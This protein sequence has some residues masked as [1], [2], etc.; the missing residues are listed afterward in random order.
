LGGP[1][2]F[3]YCRRCG[4]EHLPCWKVFDCWWESFDVVD[5]L[6]SRLSPDQFHRLSQTRP[7]PKIDSL[8]E[9]V[10]QAKKAAG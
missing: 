2:T 8:L 3:G 4:E 5:F 9:L 6:K 1:V 7:K 10:E